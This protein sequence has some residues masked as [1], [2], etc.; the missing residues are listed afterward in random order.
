M[1]G[2][3]ERSWHRWAQS[4]GKTPR[5]G[6]A[7]GQAGGLPRAHL[8][9]VRKGL[10]VPLPE[11][12]ED[13]LVKLIGWRVILRGRQVLAVVCRSPIVGELEACT[14]SLPPALR[15]GPGR[16]SGVGGEEA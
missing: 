10:S 13:T 15:E 3:M 14:L 4:P 2:L 16:V 1:T 11:R 9:R 12:S 8:G 6:V 7:P 5:G